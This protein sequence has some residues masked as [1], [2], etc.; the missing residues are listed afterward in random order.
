[1]MW[2]WQ[3]PPILLFVVITNNMSLAMSF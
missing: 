1:V 2:T 3:R